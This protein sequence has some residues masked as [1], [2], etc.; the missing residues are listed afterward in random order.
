M[1]QLQCAIACLVVVSLAGLAVAR[2]KSD[3]GTWARTFSESVSDFASTGRNP[4]FV[5]EPGYVLTYQGTEGRRKVELTIT[6]LDETVTIDGVETR[7]V[8]E[9]ELHD[10]KLV[11]VSRNFFAVST[12]TKNVYY[13]GEDSDTY[14]NG[15]VVDREGS[16]RA[17]AGGA[18][19]GLAMPAEARVGARYYQ[20]IS[21]N[22]AMDRAEIVSTTETVTVPAGRFENCVRTEETTPLEPGEREYK[23]YA[24]GVGLVVDGALRLVSYGFAKR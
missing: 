6:V 3:D 20:E 22:I 18:T 10:G 4:Y 1:K 17:V 2:Q 8:E 5:L 9:R 23:L 21:P 16:W 19:Y 12:R 7:V 24:P 13:F 14:R 15:K 11:E